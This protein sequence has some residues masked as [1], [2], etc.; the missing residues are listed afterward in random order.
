MNVWL[1]LLLGGI[2]TY[3]TRLSF[4]FLLGIWEMPSW[5]QRCLR[6]VP[7]AVMTAL[8]FPEL[9][10]QS[11]KFFVSFGNVRLFAGIAAIV[12]ALLTK[13]ILFTILAG[14]FVMMLFNFLA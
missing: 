9:F 3:L 8:I 5:M 14:I 2:L 12:A 13:S 10:I 6:Y 4:I 7:P 1:V 11:E